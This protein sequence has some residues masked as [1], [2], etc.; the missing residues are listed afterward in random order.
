MPGC[1]LPADLGAEIRRPLL[2][3]PGAPQEACRKARRHQEAHKLAAD[4]LGDV[5][6]D[7]AALGIDR[8]TAAHAGVERAGEVDALVV[9]A[10]DQAAIAAFDDGEA[11]IE[12]IA[13]RI[14]ALALG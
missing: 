13:H 6:A 1:E 12:G 4:L 11:E 14:E 3:L 10:L 5:D 2:L 8:G 9:A 7:D